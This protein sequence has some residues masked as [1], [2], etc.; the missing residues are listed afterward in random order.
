[1]MN[2]IYRI[3]NISPN[4][5]IIMRLDWGE[6][7]KTGAGGGVYCSG[8]RGSARSAVKRGRGGKYG[9]KIDDSEGRIPLLSLYYDNHPRSYQPKVV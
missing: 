7:G 9:V 3:N 1:M 5:E 4:E 8:M 2:I 6:V